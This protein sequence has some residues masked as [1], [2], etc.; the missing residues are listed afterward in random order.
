[1]ARQLDLWGDESPDSAKQPNRDRPLTL[2]D[3]D[4]NRTIT[5]ESVRQ[6]LTN[7]ERQI[8]FAGEAQFDWPAPDH[9]RDTITVDRLRGDIDGPAHRFVIKRGDFVEVFFNKDKVDYGSVVGISHARSEVRVLFDDATEGVWFAAGCIYPAVPEKPARPTKTKARMEEIREIAASAKDTVNSVNRRLQKM[10]DYTSLKCIKLVRTGSMAGRPKL[11]STQEAMAFFK[12]YWEDNPAN[13]QEHFVVA[14]LDTKHRVQSVIVVTVG[15]L[16]ASLV[17]PREVFKGAIIEGASAG[18]I[19]HNH[20]S[21]DPTPSREDHQV[22]E[23]LTEAGKLIGI[24]LLDHI[25]HGDGTN[26][27][28]SIRES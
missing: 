6:L 18:I 5:K 3:V 20:P 16:D 24:N 23:R 26:E 8:T 14:N 12:K 21:G 22:T 4:A 15:T 28:I 13:D 1:M 17:H 9:D 10:R 7:P 11:T 25:V 19:S 27:V 2:A